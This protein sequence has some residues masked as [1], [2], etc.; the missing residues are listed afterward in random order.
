MKLFK[1]A[2]EST[3][4][5]GAHSIITQ[6]SYPFLTFSRIPLERGRDVANQFGIAGLLAPLFDHIPNHNIPLPSQLGP[7]LRPPG[8]PMAFPPNMRPGQPYMVHYMPP[9]MLPRPPMFPPGMYPPFPPGT[10]PRLPPGMQ[11]LPPGMYTPQPLQPAPHVGPHPMPYPG[12]PGMPTLP[13]PPHLQVPSLAQSSSQSHK[14]TRKRIREEEAQDNPPNNQGNQDIDTPM[15][16]GEADPSG[17]QSQSNSGPPTKRARVDSGPV[18]GISKPNEAPPPEEVP[19]TID[20]KALRARSQPPREP[21]LAALPLYEPSA[22][23]L[24]TRFFTRATVDRIELRTALP[25][26]T[27][28]PKILAAIQEDAVETVITLLL[29][30]SD[31]CMRTDINAVL[32]DKGHT[33]LHLAA[34]LG[35][36]A[37]LEALIQNGA[38]I[39]RGNFSGETA[40]MRAVTS[41]LNHEAQTFLP[42]LTAL[43]GTLRTMDGCKRT[44]LHHVAHVSGVKGH[45]ASARFYMESILIWVEKHQGKSFTGLL[46]LKDE[47]GDTA[48]NISARVG[49]M[50]LVG[51]LRECGA[52]AGIANKFGMKP[53]D[54]G[55][56]VEVS[57]N[58]IC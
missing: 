16:N 58:K 8:M 55:V 1:E 7:P 2:M 31:D 19:T 33:V 50:A 11:P 41:P 54:F 29:D 40:L 56:D 14:E 47:S 36:V 5:H 49:S 38:E 57:A 52:D 34:A 4:E 27:K 43:R 3:K 23:E 10:A 39:H 22:E 9:G 20:P 44:V 18:N 45:A 30:H 46:D 25:K 12:L 48:L 15:V 24:H 53:K 37:L 42:V 13:I 6:K 32:D 26:S 28:R 17:S 35:K 51:M 21:N